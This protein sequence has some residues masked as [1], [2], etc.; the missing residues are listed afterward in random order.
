MTHSTS[1][2][3]DRPTRPTRITQTMLTRIMEFR[4]SSQ[5]GI[6]DMA[7]RGIKIRVI[8][9]MEMEISPINMD[10]RTKTIK[11]C[12][13]RVAK[14]MFLKMDRIKN[15]VLSEFLADKVIRIKMITLTS[16][17]DHIQT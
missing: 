3:I 5:V 14:T 9:I 12:H 7:T 13:T 16:N 2:S 8:T 17:R 10:T 15:K 6:R 11:I 4:T 1:Q